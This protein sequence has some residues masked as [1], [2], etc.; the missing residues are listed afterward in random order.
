MA[1]TVQ[2]ISHHL[3]A[4]SGNDPSAGGPRRFH[5]GE[6]RLIPWRFPLLLT[7]LRTGNDAGNMPDE[8]PTESRR[9]IAV[10]R[11]FSGYR[12]T[13]RHREYS[14]NSKNGIEKIQHSRAPILH[15]PRVREA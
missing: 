4:R 6:N 3:L 9:I 11:R 10:F 5:N 2:G 13:V 7:V 14:K 8:A 1:A 15:G 12:V